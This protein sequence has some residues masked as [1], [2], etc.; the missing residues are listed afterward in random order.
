MGPS[1]PL[2]PP[3]R[4]PKPLEP[5]RV[6]RRVV[7]L[8][9]VVGLGHVSD[10]EISRIACVRPLLDVV[11]IALAAIDDGNIGNEPRDEDSREDAGWNQEPVTVFREE[12]RPR[13]KP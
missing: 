9:G 10:M 2:P 4:Q 7:E 11:H 1:R 3:Q 12:C 6:V 13:E 8:A 5:T